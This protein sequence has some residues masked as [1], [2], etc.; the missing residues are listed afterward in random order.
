MNNKS[1]ISS[2]II[3]TITASGIFI[4]LILQFIWF[5]NTY[6]LIEKELYD[7]CNF[8]LSKAIEAELFQRIENS[9]N[10]VRIEKGPTDISGEIISSGKINNYNQLKEQIQNFSFQDGIQCN[11]TKLDSIFSNKILSAISFVPD[12]KIYIISNEEY[13]KNINKYNSNNKIIIN[14]NSFQ[15]VVFQLLNPSKSILIKSKDIFI[16]SIILII[17]IITIFIIQLVII[18]RENKYITY[19]RNYMMIMLHDLK[20]PLNSISMINAVLKDHVFEISESKK[21]YYLDYEK[22][23]IDLIVQYI[24]KLISFNQ[25][26]RINAESCDGVLAYDYFTEVKDNYLSCHSFPFKDV[27]ISMNCQ[28]DKKCRIYVDPFLFV[29]AINNIIDNAIKYSGKR[30]RI[31]ISVESNWRKTIVRIKDNGFGIAKKDQKN[32]FKS[33]V[34]GSN[35]DKGAVKGYGLGLALVKS[36]IVSNYG[37]ISVKSEENKGSEFIIS[38]P[39]R[40]H[41]YRNV[42]SSNAWLVK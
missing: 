35:S 32:I 21:K 38:L 29:E 24:D 27:T 8:Y 40:R 23:Q 41:S 9:N 20:S 10:S 1:L 19:L 18:I 13:N 25:P 12:H 7:K 5:N 28:S 31:E 2:S 42:F 16:I 37:R 11:I 39:K 17:T 30:V 33:Y 34:R 14:I 26:N 3:K 15:K 6:R 22:I 4:L 36:I